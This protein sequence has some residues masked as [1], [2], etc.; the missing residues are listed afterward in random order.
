[1]GNI[2]SRYTGFQFLE[3]S[4]ESPARMKK[5]N[6]FKATEIHYFVTMDSET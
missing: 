1:M 2:L 4:T 5:I 6:S 3:Q